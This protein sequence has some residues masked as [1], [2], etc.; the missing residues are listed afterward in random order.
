[1][2]YQELRDYALQASLEHHLCNVDDLLEEG[3]TLNEIMA[4]VEEADNTAVVIY[5]PYE[6]YESS[7]LVESIED[8]RGVKVFEFMHVLRQV[9]GEE[10]ADTFKGAN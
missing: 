3:K 1:M 7:S 8:M 9:N 6:Y 4:M 5:E 2:N 10:W